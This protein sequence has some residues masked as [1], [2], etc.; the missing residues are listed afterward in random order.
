[1]QKD[2]EEKL[3]CEFARIDADKEEFNINKAIN[4]V[5]RHIKQSSKKL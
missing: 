5:F 1:M 2:I 3:V 4:E